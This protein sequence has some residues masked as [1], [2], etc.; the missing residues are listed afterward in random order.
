MIRVTGSPG[1][2]ALVNATSMSP[3]V[4]ETLPETLMD[5]EPGEGWPGSSKVPPVSDSE[6]MV[7]GELPAGR[8]L[9]RWFFTSL[10]RVEVFTVAG[11]S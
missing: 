1:C 2:G 3:P 9:F 10:S 6:P 5:D 7:R 4:I 8:T 11:A